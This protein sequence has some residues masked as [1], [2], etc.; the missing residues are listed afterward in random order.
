MG[1]LNLNPGQ[2]QIP[3][4]PRA[5]FGVVTPTAPSGLLTKLAQ[6]QAVP[7]PTGPR[8][9]MMSRRVE[10]KG[11]AT[12]G[13]HGVFAPVLGRQDAILSPRWGSTPEPEPQ[14]V[15]TKPPMDSLLSWSADESLRI[16]RMNASAFEGPARPPAKKSA[17]SRRPLSNALPMDLVDPISSA[18]G[19]ASVNAH[20]QAPEKRG[21][22]METQREDE[23]ESETNQLIVTS[24]VVGSDQGDDSEDE[25]PLIVTVL[26][27]TLR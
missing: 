11:L 3:T 17:I 19:G 2:G 1:V 21:P 16:L 10:Q 23:L 15:V 24:V 14:V 9:G 22:G 27:S 8:W 20:E 13:S 12:K 4:G 26:D 25:V 6:A 18:P 7:T 5:A